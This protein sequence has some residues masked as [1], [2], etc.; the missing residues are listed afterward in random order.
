[1]AHLRG[2]SRIDRACLAAVVLLA[3]CSFGNSHYFMPQEPLE[4]KASQDPARA[5]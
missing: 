2:P 3:V 4:G 1:M 5:T